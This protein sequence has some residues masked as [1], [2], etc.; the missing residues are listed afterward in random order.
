[1]LLTKQS[2]E[3]YIIDIEIILKIRLENTSVDYIKAGH[4]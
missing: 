2:P 1:M 3:T 4:L